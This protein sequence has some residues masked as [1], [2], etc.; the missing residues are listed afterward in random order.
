MPELPLGFWVFHDLIED[1]HAAHTDG[2]LET[3]FAKP[4]FDE[5]AFLAGGKA[6][7]DAVAIFWDGLNEQRLSI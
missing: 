1:Q 4:D 2:E 3:A 7:L 6:I 5:E